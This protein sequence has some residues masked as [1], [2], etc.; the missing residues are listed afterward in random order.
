MWGVVDLCMVF[1]GLLTFKFINGGIGLIVFVL[2]NVLVVYNI[3]VIF[4]VGF[5]GIDWKTIYLVMYNMISSFVNEWLISID[6]FVMYLEVEVM[7]NIGQV[8][9]CEVFF[10]EL[11]LVS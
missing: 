9:V 2:V 7:G 6:V 8:V 1:G 11:I 3:G 4:V 10:F 5:V